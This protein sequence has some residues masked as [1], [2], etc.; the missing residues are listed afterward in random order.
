MERIQRTHTHTQQSRQLSQ[1]GL[2]S[3]IQL[4]ESIGYHTHLIIDIR[5][6]PK[7]W[8]SWARARVIATRHLQFV[9]IRMGPLFSPWST[10]KF[11]S[12]FCAIKIE[13]QINRVHAAQRLPRAPS[14][15][16]EILSIRWVPCACV[17]VWVAY[18]IAIRINFAACI[19]LF[20]DVLL[21]IETYSTTFTTVQMATIC[22]PM[23]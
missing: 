14:I 15:H 8:I 9:C 19:R 4:G 21:H 20:T 11:R 13:W 3:M 10:V 7:I 1:S 6:Y 16:S 23:C 5:E 12:Q 2:H 18:R 22:A 17:C